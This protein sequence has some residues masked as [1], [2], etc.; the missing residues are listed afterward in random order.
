MWSLFPPSR[1]QAVE[2]LDSPERVREEL[3][4]NLRDIRRLNR[5]FGGSVL[6]RRYFFALNRS[7]GKGA[8]LS[9]SLLDVAT[10]SGDI[11]AA[12]IVWGRKHGIE[13]TATGLDC[14]PD[15]LGEAARYTGGS[16]SFVLGDARALPWPD[17]SFDV[18]TCSL[19]L[20]HFDPASAAQVL[21]E[22]AR[23]ARVGVIVTDLRRSRL[24]YV[25]TW[26]VTH[27]VARNRLTRHD[28]P[29]SVLRAYTAR[30]V[31]ALAASAGLAGAHV[32]RHLFFRLALL[33]STALDHDRSL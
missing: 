14:S 20:H 32:R 10:G 3:A 8:D 22:V 5:W 26:L 25:A 17:S 31:Q 27:T 7:A 6:V 13:I 33:W 12:I 28:G 19:A 18:V 23:V 2:L 21:R 24:A 4:A 15:V 16:V 11:P 1:S 30:E 29:L 9:V